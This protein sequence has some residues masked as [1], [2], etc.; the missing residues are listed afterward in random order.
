[1]RISMLF[2]LL[3]GATAAV[4]A[5]SLYK[6]GSFQSLT[7]DARVRQVGDLLTVLIHESASATSAADTSASR[8][9]NVGIDLRGPYSGRSAAIGTDNQLDGRGRTQREGRVLGQITVAVQQVL[10]SGDIVI[11]GE[12][13]LEINNE[14]QRIALEGQVRPQDVSSTN[15]VLSSRVANARIQYAGHGD[16]ADRQRPSWWHRMLTWFG[17]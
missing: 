3:A 2:L 5:E 16:L 9:A 8:S 12:Q 17:I 15:V 11:K 7:A 13:V 6:P 1:M 4:G 14:S 10:P